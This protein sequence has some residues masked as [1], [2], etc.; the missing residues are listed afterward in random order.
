[1]K[2]R[3]IIPA[4]GKAVR[5]NGLPKELLPTDLHECGLTR[6]VRIAKEIDSEVVIITN[7]DKHVLHER[8]LR[9]KE[10][11]DGCVFKE[12][13]T[14]DEMWGAIRLGLAMDCAGG[15][16]MPDTVTSI[17]AGLSYTR[18]ESIQFGVFDTDTPE[19]YS[20]LTNSNP[21][22]ILT[23][24]KVPGS[25][26]ACKAWGMVLWPEQVTNFFLANSFDHYDRAFEAAA[27]QFGHGVFPLSYYF[28]LGSFPSYLAYL[29]MTHLSQPL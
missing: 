19:R 26:G 11:L 8:I 28:D 4:A 1:M 21:F 12:Q 9:E 16:I 7:R 29:A 14:L 27:R 15:L 5:F 3:I 25:R 6:A 13:N 22:T 23:K 20:I 18:P 24:Q 17:A 10:L 2:R